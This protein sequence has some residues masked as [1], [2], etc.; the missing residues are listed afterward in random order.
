MGR[1]NQSGIFYMQQDVK[2]IAAFPEEYRRGLFSR[3][4]RKFLLI[5]AALIF[6]FYST[7]GLLS[8]FVKVNDAP[9]EKE[10]LKIQERYAQ[11]V[12]NQPK[13]K[14][15]V[16][17]EE[18]NK[19]G[20]KEEVQVAPTEEKKEDVKVDR[21]KE[22]FVEKVQRKEAGSEERRQARE[23]VTKQIQS[24]GIFA[25]ITASGGSGSGAS[26]ASDLLGSAS[27][28][29]GDISN[30]NISKG[31]F[32]SKKI[33]QASASEHKGSRTTD[34][35]I[36]KESLG[37]A[38]VKQVATAANV[39]IT[40]APAEITGESS[41]SSERSQSAIGRVV[42]REA[43]RLK[44]VYE[45]WLKRDPALSGRLMVKFT[46]LP[47]GAVSSVSIVKSTT[48]NQDFDDAILRYIRR[49][50]FPEVVNGSPVEVVYPFIFEGQS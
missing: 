31:S 9:T 25:A 30:I 49:W 50:Q 27:D 24:S 19:V 12:L 8:V 36:Q 11:L 17:V 46:I 21:E 20:P 33:E 16:K 23:E 5:F 37:R 34:V 42:S 38:E 28:G 35:G 40:S 43:Q 47:T 15:E 39:N 44:R 6:V 45:D 1:T 26:A 4:E 18:K 10:V 13:P 32:A 14:V 48:N 29:I 41:T 7:V 22:S 3:F 2:N